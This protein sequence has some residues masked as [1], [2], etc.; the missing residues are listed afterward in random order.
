MR[1]T[2]AKGFNPD[3]TTKVGV[4]AKTET[5]LIRVQINEFE[6]G[7]YV[8]IRKFYKK[9]DMAEYA[10]TGQGI[11]IPV[12][13]IGA[14]RKL[15]SKAREQLADIEET[16]SARKKTKPSKGSVPDKTERKTA[17]TS[18]RKNKT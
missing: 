18:T 7:T 13:K 2:V 8:D 9:K 10:P 12:D 6:N 1:C 11:S 5:G 3:N 14:L 4:F 16:P 17:K 15:L